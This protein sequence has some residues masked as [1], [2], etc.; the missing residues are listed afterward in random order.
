MLLTKTT[1]WPLVLFF[2]PTGTFDNSPPFQRWVVERICLRSPVRD[3]RR[4]EDRRAVSVAPM[5][6]RSLVA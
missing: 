6:L 5:G 1:G 4:S 3:D 2:V